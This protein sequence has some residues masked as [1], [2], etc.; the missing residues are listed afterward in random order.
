MLP[1]RAPLLFIAFWSSVNGMATW[2]GMGRHTAAGIE[3]GMGVGVE[4]SYLESGKE[5]EMD[6]GQ[7]I[8]VCVSVCA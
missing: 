2:V 8:C 7:G 1:W 5:E 4:G 3:E 6:E